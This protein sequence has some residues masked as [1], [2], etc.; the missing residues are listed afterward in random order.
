[1]SRRYKVIKFTVY[2]TGWKQSNLTAFIFGR[3]AVRVLAKKP[4]TMYENFT[5]SVNKDPYA[6]DLIL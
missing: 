2:T 4:R 3:Y 5:V 6:N 1:V